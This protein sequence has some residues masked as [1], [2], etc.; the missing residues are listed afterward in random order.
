MYT[1][2]SP[3]SYGVNV[4]FLPCSNIEKIAGIDFAPVNVGNL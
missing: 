4:N 3:F 2:L 1:L